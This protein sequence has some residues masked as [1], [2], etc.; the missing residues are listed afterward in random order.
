L[1]PLHPIER[2][3]RTSRLSVRG[4]KKKRPPCRRAGLS[5]PRVW[6]T[7]PT[8]QRPFFGRLGR[9]SRRGGRAVSS[10]RPGAAQREVVRLLYVATRHQVRALAAGITERARQPAS[11]KS[12]PGEEKVTPPL[13]QPGAPRRRPICK[14]VKRQTVAM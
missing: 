9:G 4:T 1:P 3:A 7:P 10:S 6:L 8:P 2:R 13:A 12:A 5:F 11:R 14:S